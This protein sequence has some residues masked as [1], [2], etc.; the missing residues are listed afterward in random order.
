MEA[1]LL[2]LVPVVKPGSSEGER[3]ARVAFGSN[4]FSGPSHRR[5]INERYFDDLI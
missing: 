4:Y 5:A 3:A 2:S 1:R